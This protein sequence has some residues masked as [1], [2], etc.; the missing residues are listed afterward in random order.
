MRSII[1][2]CNLSFDL[3]FQPVKEGARHS[4]E[5]GLSQKQIGSSSKNE[6]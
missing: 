4:V 3:K 2:K 1:L 5:Y 6:F